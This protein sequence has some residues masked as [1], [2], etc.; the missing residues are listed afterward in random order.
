ME[1]KLFWTN[2]SQKEIEKIYK[3]YREKAGSR[4]AKKIVIGIY[5]E[6]LKLQRQPKI[7]Q[8]EELLKSRKQEFRYLIYKNYKVIYWINDKEN[9]IEI[10]DVFDTRQNP[11]KIERKK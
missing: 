3:Y 6:T 10:S 11:I 9:R 1:L 8:T 7:G 2:F 4:I 5:N